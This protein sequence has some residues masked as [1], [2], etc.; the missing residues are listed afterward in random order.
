MDFFCITEPN[1]K[2]T[3]GRDCY[4]NQSKTAVIINKTQEHSVITYMLDECFV[5][6]KTKSHVIY[7][8]YVSPNC[9]D[10]YF[11][12][13]LERLELTVKMAKQESQVIITG[14]FNAKNTYWGGE[15]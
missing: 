13:A 4:I 1:T 9:S 8:F 12:S 10:G 15:R 5:Y 6:V 11:S 3:R 7:S 2:R 14:D